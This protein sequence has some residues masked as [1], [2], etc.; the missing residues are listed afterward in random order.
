MYPGDLVFSRLNAPYGRSCILPNKEEKCIIAVD[1]VVLRTNEDKRYLCYVTQTEGYHKSVEDY[2]NGSTMQRISR[3]NLGDIYFPLPTKKEQKLIA[4]FLDEKID[5]IDNIICDLDNQIE[6]AKYNY[7]YFFTKM[8]VKILQTCFKLSCILLISEIFNYT[9]IN[10]I[11][12]IY[13]IISLFNIYI[14]IS[15]YKYI[16]EDIRKTLKLEVSFEID[17]NTISDKLFKGIL[18]YGK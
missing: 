5:I 12:I 3:T 6:I 7:N 18:N 17:L 15:N 10:I 9:I 14:I 1:N 16:I 4:D 2:S 11:A 13:T 8:I